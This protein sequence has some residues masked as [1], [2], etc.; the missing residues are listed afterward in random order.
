MQVSVSDTGGL[1]RRL[2]VA[3][4]QQE[5]AREVQQR[6]KQL[7]RTARLK[8]F[9]PG[10]APLAVI[11]KQF[12]DQVRAE[13]LND[14]MRSSFS[15]AVTQE[16]LRPAGGPRIEPLELGPE[17]DLKYAAHFE[18]LPEIQVN[19]PASIQIERPT[20]TVSEA[21]VEGMI[22][23]MRAQRP[24]Y[25]AVER[26]ARDG[27][28]VLFDYQARIGGK[29]IED[30]DLKD[31]RIVLGA[32]Q[33]MPE[34]EEGLKGARAGEVRDI[35]ATFPDQ[36]PNKRLA[37]QTADLRLTIKAVE[38]HSL[39]AMDEEFFRAYGVESGG[40][41]EMRAEVRKSMERELSGVIKNRLRAQV[42]E[43]LYKN[44]PIQVPRALVEEQ[45]QQLQIDTARRMGI[46]DA[47]ALPPAERFEEPAQR[48]AA[49]GLLISQIVQSQGMSVDRDR[50]R[51]RLTELVESYPDPEQARRAYLQNQDAMRQIESAALEEQVI[52][53]VVGQAQVTD[54]AYSFKELTGFGEAQHDHEH[55]D[56]HDHDHEHHA[57][58]AGGEQQQEV[59]GT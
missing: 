23:N 8:G 44:N 41:E 55:E 34:L 26:E 57:A 49:L 25:T 52:D 33:A 48:R 31:V 21:D 30:G 20:A 51:A 58:P 54:K 2:E 24:V 16:K 37:G 13:V 40:L 43:G 18:V 17:A 56:A 4:P 39:P 27:D 12:G 47:R 6:L 53:W 32:R 19:S 59:S 1:T 46:R 7:S 3:V 50:V 29:L 5:V 15:Q 45:V 9:R 28:R 35:S 10:K 22:E 14:L 11:T 36:H 42:L 38:E